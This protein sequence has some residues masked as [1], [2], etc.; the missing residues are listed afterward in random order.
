MRSE[1]L[2][3]CFKVVIL[4]AHFPLHTSNFPNLYAKKKQSP[5]TRIPNTFSKESVKPGKITKTEPKT[6]PDIK[7]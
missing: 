1:I 5:A 3:I 7:K 2:S 6:N 4:K